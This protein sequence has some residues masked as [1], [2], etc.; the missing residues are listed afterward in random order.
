[1]KKI[2]FEVIVNRRIKTSLFEWLREEG[3]T[4]FDIFQSWAKE[5]EDKYL[6]TEQFMQKVDRKSVV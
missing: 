4:S 5:N 6:F 2:D 1:M 3:F